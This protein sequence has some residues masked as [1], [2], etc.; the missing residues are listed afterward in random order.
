M[1]GNYALFIGLRYSFSRKRSRFTGLIA[2]V[3]MLGMV[4]GVA[5]LITVLS[6]MNGFSGELQGRILSLVPHGYLESEQ[7]SIDNW[8]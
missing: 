4:L 3:S 5:S 1:S 8:Q 6:I 7:G 2:L